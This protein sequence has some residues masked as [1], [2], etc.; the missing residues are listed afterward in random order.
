MS[1]DDGLEN[2][3]PAGRHAHRVADDQEQ[4][5]YEGSPVL[6][7]EL[8]RGFIWIAIGLVIIAAPIV[9]WIMAKEGT[10][11]FAWWWFLVALVIGLGFILVPW[12]RTKSIC[13]KIT[14]Y[15]IDIE[16][17]LLSKRIDTLE[18]WHVDDIKLQQSF[19][20]RMLGVGTMTVYSGDDTTPELPIRGL[21]GARPLFES[22]KQRVIA[23][24]RQRGVVKMDLG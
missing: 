6:R 4:I 5:F 2:M 12:I 15:R 3:T 16:R 19:L 11:P 21:P 23:V 1:I 20:D 22:V 13:Y 14:N 17:G 7:S 8:A 9:I 24:K 18:L 10:H